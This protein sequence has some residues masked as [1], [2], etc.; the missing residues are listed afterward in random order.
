[1]W[2]KREVGSMSRERIGQNLFMR[3]V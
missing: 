3:E 1:V 2:A